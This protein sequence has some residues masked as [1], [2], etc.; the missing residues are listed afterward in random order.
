M[1]GFLPG[2]VKFFF[3]YKFR[4]L[5]ETDFSPEHGVVYRPIS[6]GNI[7]RGIFEL[8]RAAQALD[9]CGS[10][11]GSRGRVH[12]ARSGPDRRGLAAPYAQRSER[13]PGPLGRFSGPPDGGPRPQYS[14]SGL[15]SL[16]SGRAAGSPG[17]SAAAAKPDRPGD[18]RRF[19]GVSRIQRIRRDRA[20]GPRG[21]GGGAARARSRSAA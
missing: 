21:S 2:G 6:A 16:D 4:Y 11:K 10:R 20:S 12:R 13:H 9:R 7:V 8:P 14:R 5:S 17:R 19:L 15:A 3:L 1:I 18:Q